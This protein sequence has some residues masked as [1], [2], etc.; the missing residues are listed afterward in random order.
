MNWVLGGLILA[1][2]GLVLRR[3]LG[4]G[5]R[6]NPRLA[7]LARLGPE[8]HAVYHPVA[9]EVETHA[10]ILSISLNDAFEERAALHHDMA[11]RMV[12][13]SAGEWDR[14]AEMLMALLNILAKR[15][16][17]AHLAVPARRIVPD[18]FKSRVMMD[19]LHMHELLDQLV[20][21]SHRRFQ[22]Q[23]RLL[24]RAIETLTKEFRYTCRY[25][26]RIQDRS[27]EVWIRLDL[28]FHDFDLIAKETLLAFRALLACLPPAAL[29]DLT[30]DLRTLLQ[31]GVRTLP[32]HANR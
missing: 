5:A 16:T 7:G 23:I 3:M 24:R 30:A 10:A 27:P 26:E 8:L 32:A 31:P 18:H 9:Q 15:A 17:N 19:Y 13:L 21:N 2:V 11:W 1:G 22:L 29:A 14:L 4:L 6:N 25:L 20:F 28:Y 12:R